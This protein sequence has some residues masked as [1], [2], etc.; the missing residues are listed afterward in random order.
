VPLRFLSK[1]KRKEGTR[2]VEST[3][4]L[5]KEYNGVTKTHPNGIIYVV[6]GAGGAKLDNPEQQTQSA[7]WQGSTTRVIATTHSL[8][9]VDVRDRELT[10]RQIGA[11]GEELDRFVITK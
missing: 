11:E 5:D 10:I 4:T 7:P 2:L 9:S 8:T 3:V 6:T 1:G